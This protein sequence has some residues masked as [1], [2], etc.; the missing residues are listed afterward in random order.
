MENKALTE[1]ELA[2]RWGVTVKMLQDWRRLDKGIDY[3]KLGRSVRY[4]LHVVEKFEQE[5][6]RSASNGN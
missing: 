5:N 6:M 2:N 1:I 3:L 4:P